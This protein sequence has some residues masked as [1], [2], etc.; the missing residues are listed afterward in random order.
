MDNEFKE[1]QTSKRFRHSD[2]RPK[3]AV[4]DRL[5]PKKPET[6]RYDYMPLRIPRTDVLQQVESLGILNKPAKMFSPHDKW[7]KAKIASSIKTMIMIWDND[8]CL[9]KRILVNTGSSVN[10]L[11]KDTFKQ[12]G[13]PCYKVI[14]LRGP[15][16]LQARWL[17]QKGKLQFP[18]PLKILDTW[19]RFSLCL[20]CHHTIV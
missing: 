17:N 18:F 20:H 3:P 19:W 6:P 8:Q 12:M 13:I 7:N 14:P 9:V 15:I 1:I 2:H 11:F 10:V 4:H 16:G 5:W